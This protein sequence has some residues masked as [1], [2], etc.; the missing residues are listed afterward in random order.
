MSDRKV[1][2]VV[3][4]IESKMNEILGI[5][6]TQDILLKIAINK[7]NSL[8]VDPI[9]NIPGDRSQM[10]EKNDSQARKEVDSLLR[11]QFE[12]SD[13]YFN[14]TENEKESEKKD[15]NSFFSNKVAEARERDR[16]SPLAAA[17]READKEDS[18]DMYEHVPGNAE[19]A[20][21]SQ[22]HRRTSNSSGEKK[23]VVRSGEGMVSVKQKIVDSEGRSIPLATVKITSE[24][25]TSKSI[26]TDS[27]GEWETS[28]FP[29]EYSVQ[30]AKKFVS[31]PNRKPINSK[32]SVK[33][34][35]AQDIS[36]E[37]RI[38]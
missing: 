13:E 4:D 38:V 27:R 29:G 11:N 18:N 24:D 12:N 15:T 10:Y 17:L 6:K 16:K 32:Y 34:D 31:D 14:D 20:T 3:L 1:S 9:S 23:S 2:D 19:L 8:T 21:S 35:G 5:I 22:R 26:R 28:L 7:I 33:I 30:I 25:G 37:Q 36:L